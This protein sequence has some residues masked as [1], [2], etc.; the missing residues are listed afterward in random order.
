[1]ELGNVG[2][3]YEGRPMD[4]IVSV[5]G[6]KYAVHNVDSNRLN[7]NFAQIN[8][9]ADHQA[10]FEFCLVDQQTLQNVT[11]PQFSITVYDLGA[12]RTLAAP[13]NSPAPHSTRFLHSSTHP[14]PS[15]R[16]HRQR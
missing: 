1:M 8:L 10:D 9:K 15:G 16:A 12:S 6:G 11:L 7:G 4:I 2:H 3:S 5:E 13:P 14:T